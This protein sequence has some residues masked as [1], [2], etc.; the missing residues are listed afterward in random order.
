MEKG[1]LFFPFSFTK[2]TI[3][4]LSPCIVTTHV[5]LAIRKGKQTGKQTDGYREREWEREAKEENKSVAFGCEK[6][7]ETRWIMI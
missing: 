1:V 3:I 4:L 7:R 5:L 6:K 2:A